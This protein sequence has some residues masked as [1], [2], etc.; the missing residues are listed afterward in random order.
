MPLGYR[1]WQNETEFAALSSLIIHGYAKQ[2]LRAINL[3][4]MQAQCC[5]TSVMNTPCLQAGLHPLHASA[6]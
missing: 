1:D 6:F 2:L 3:C 4:L 5:Y